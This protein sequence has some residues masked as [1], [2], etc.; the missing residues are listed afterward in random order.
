MLD[1]DNLSNSYKNLWVDHFWWGGSLKDYDAHY[2]CK[3]I[4]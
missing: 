1:F 4:E 3:I 2:E